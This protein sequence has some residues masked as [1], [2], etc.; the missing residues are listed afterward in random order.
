M[1]KE[2][3]SRIENDVQ[4]RSCEAWLKLCEY[5]DKVA[6]SGKSEFSPGDEL[7]PELFSQIHTLPE[8]IAKLTKVRKMWLY[9]SQLKRIPPEPPYYYVTR[10][11][12]GASRLQQPKMDEEEIW[13]ICLLNQSKKKTSKAPKLFSLI[14]KIW[15]K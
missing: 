14:R 3:I 8:S 15:G 10:P 9:G 2:K 4:D 5:V 1:T 6:E 12:K 11:H 7:G 13:D